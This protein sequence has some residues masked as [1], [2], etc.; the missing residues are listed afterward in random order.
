M[1]DLWPNPINDQ[2]MKILK[3]SKAHNHSLV[4]LQR[5]R[6]NINNRIEGL[7][8]KSSLFWKV[9][10]ENCG[11]KHHQLRHVLWHHALKLWHILIYLL[12]K[13]LSCLFSFSF[14]IWNIYRSSQSDMEDLHNRLIDKAVVEPVQGGG[15][16]EGLHLKD[17]Q[18]LHLLLPS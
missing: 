2:L 1:I 8:I 6:W 17:V 5:F 7:I 18:V 16:V 11:L 9:K 12:K 15:V 4:V 13:T 10:Q 3:T 14:S